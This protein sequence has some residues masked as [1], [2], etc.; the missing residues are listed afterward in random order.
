MKLIKISLITFLVVG[1]IGTSSTLLIAG[2]ER[3]V[4][5]LSVSGPGKYKA[6]RAVGT[7]TFCHTPHNA[8]PTRGLWN[9]SLPGITYKLYESSTLEAKLNQPTGSSR[10]CLSCHDGTIALG[11]PRVGPKGIALGSLKGKTSLGTDLSD[12]HPISFVYD[13]DLAVRRGELAD[14]LTLPKALR[15]DETGQ[16]QCTTCHDPHTDK[17]PGFLAMDNRNSSLCVSC[18]RLKFWQASPHALSPATWKGIHPDPFS[19]SRFK[20][21]SENGCLNCHKVHAAA[22]PE[23]LLRSQDEEENCYVC[24]NGAVAKRDVEVEFKKFSFHPVEMSQWV[25]DPKENPFSMERHVS[26]FDC[27]NPHSSQQDVKGISLSGTEVAQSAFEYQVCY[28]CHGVSEQSFSS[29][30]REDNVTNVRIEMEPSNPSYHP[31][32]AV[33]R[34]PSVSGFEPG[35]T[36]SS[37]ISC[38]DCHSPHGSDYDMLLKWEYRMEDLTSESYQSYSL[39]YRC[40]NRNSL[41]SGVSGFPHSKHVVDGRTSCSVCH[42]AHGSRKNPSL[43][44]FMVRDRTEKTIVSFSKSGRLDFQKVGMNHGRCYLSCHGSD[45]DPKEY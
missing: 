4:H 33:G 7:C 3:T 20:T 16:L 10:L 32:V 25:H 45:H 31:I 21:V 14:P 1:I 15:L 12:D 35:Y 8:N 11:N 37:I 2:V 18:H 13:L 19:E 43:I 27:H 40:H 23:W 28:K 41:L 44:N 42:D 39:C 38:S 9:R 36:P 6:M 5:N 29:I 30:R 17:N 24:H 26:C 22:H 34:N